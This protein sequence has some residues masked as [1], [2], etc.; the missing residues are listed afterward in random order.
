[1]NTTY[2]KLK[3]ELDMDGIVTRYKDFVAVAEYMAGPNGDFF[4]AELWQPI[5]TEDETG[6]DFYNLRLENASEGLDEC[7]ATEGEAL[8]AVFTDIERRLRSQIKKASEAL[9]VVTCQGVVE[10]IYATN[11]DIKATVIDC[12]AWI[13]TFPSLPQNKIY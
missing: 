4:K 1:M 8:A 12:D 7:Y 2:L 13:A 5:E 6:E 9:T 11:P 10:S 3:V